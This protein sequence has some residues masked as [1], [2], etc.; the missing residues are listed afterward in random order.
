MG[1][2][3]RKPEEIRLE[4]ERGDWLLVRKHLTAG[5]EREAYAHLIKEGGKPGDLDIRHMGIAEVA[6]YLLDWN[7]TDA[8]DQPVKIRDASY[9][10]IFAALSA[11]DPEDCLEIVGAISK[12]DKAM[13]AERE[14]QKKILSGEP[15]P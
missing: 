11:M 9:P 8:N 6:A 5:E 1:S 10:F 15:V 2:R 3:Y 7:I 12:H 4:L 14:A 13:R